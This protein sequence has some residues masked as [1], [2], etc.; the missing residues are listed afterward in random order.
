M[1]LL[2]FYWDLLL[3]KFTNYPK[4]EYILFLAFILLLLKIFILIMHNLCQLHGQNIKL[5]SFL[6]SF[7]IS[8]AFTNLIVLLLLHRKPRGKKIKLLQRLH[9]LL[10]ACLP[11]PP[12]GFWWNNDITNILQ[13][14]IL[15]YL[16][17]IQGLLS[18]RTLK[19]SHFLSRT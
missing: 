15:I 7:T 19:P 5:S 17:S 2:H 18:V 4:L 8:L 11:P 1:F 16:V 14:A 12:Q 6:G 13:T 10:I 9:L 3:H